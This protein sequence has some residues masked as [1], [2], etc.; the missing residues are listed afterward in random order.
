M[1]LLN[2]AIQIENLNLDLDVQFRYYDNDFLLLKRW[3]FKMNKLFI[4]LN[5]QPETNND[6]LDT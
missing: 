2:G 4:K 1:I 6:F 5:D 3:I